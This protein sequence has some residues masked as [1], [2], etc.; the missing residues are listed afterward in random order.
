VKSGRERVDLHDRSYDIVVGPGVIG[1]VS[2]K[3]IVRSASAVLVVSNRKVY[4][5]Y[6]KVLTERLDE[7]GV[8]WKKV[9]LPDGERYKTMASVEKIH[10]KLVIGRYDREAVVIALGGGVIGDI[11]GFAA[12]TYMRGVRIIQIPTTLLAQVDSSVGG[13]TGVNHPKGKNLIGAFYQPSLVLADSE[14]LATLPREEILC[15]VAEIVKYGC[16]AS[17][18]FFRYLEKNIERLITLEPSVIKKAVLTSCRI[19]ADVVAQDE[20]EAG[21][22]AILNFGHTVGHAVEAVTGYNR[23]RHGYAV[24]IGMRSAAELSRIKGNLSEAEVERISGLLERAGLPT[25]I[26]KNIGKNALLKAMRHDKKVAGGAIRFALLKKIGEC[27]IIADVT[28]SEMEEAIARS[29]N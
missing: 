12:A 2:A 11:A 24:A 23:Y 1:Q 14:A 27:H 29:R 18:S 16:I 28:K 20:R 9:L 22:R 21:V 3:E 17:T 25:V 13:K 7:A 4:G 8:A 15:G 6:G 5:L 19:K 26:P 10:N